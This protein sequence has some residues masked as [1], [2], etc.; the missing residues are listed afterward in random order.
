MGAK[1]VI[2]INEDHITQDIETVRKIAFMQNWMERKEDFVLVTHAN[3]MDGL[4]TA[5]VV[6]MYHKEKNLPM[7]EEG[8]NLIYLNY[9][10]YDFDKVLEQLKG[11]V[12]LVGDF[13]FRGDENAIIEEHAYDMLTIDH[14]K[15]AFDHLQGN[16]N[17]IFDNQ[18]AGVKL[19]WDFLNPDK[20]SPEET[21][22]VVKLIN[23]RDLFLFGLQPDGS[24]E[25]T[26]GDVI[27]PRAFHEYLTKNNYDDPYPAFNLNSDICNMFED[28]MEVEDAVH[29]H[30]DEVKELLKKYE[31]K[32]KSAV[33]FKFGEH[34]VYGMNLTSKA[35]EILNVVSRN[36]RAPSFSYRIT[37]DGYMRFSFRSADKTQHVD[38]IAQIVSP[39]GGGHVA[40]SGAAVEV[41]KV[42]LHEFIVNRNFKLK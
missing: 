27:A 41:E 12:V 35:S 22:Y 26:C 42:D 32:A 36:H 10:E 20:S 24:D 18:R 5:G 38:K 23:D 9:K 29:L 16:P 14:H 1:P 34:T 19:M 40:A 30:I 2:S 33:A 8:K 13:S 11:K 4:G 6:A 28:D 21:P 25:P 7:L 3:C 37:N 31:S 17:F 39:E 15:T